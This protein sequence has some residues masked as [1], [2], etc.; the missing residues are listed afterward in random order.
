M[1]KADDAETLP[2]LST[3]P[4]AWFFKIHW[5]SCNVLKC[6]FL[7]DFQTLWDRLNVLSLKYNIVIRAKNTL[8]LLDIGHIIDYN[9]EKIF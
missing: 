2:I 4:I 1:D 6:D 5:V 3:P 7:I 8:D 9:D